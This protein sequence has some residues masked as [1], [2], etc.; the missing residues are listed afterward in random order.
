MK[1]TI[2]VLN[3]LPYFQNAHHSVTICYVWEQTDLFYGSV[4][5]WRNLET[6]HSS[7]TFPPSL[8]SARLRFNYFPVVPFRRP[9]R[10]EARLGR[11]AC[12][13]GNSLCPSG[14]KPLPRVVALWNQIK[15][16]LC[17]VPSLL[18]SQF[19]EKAI[20]P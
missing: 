10:Y 5:E 19:P 9:H 14:K 12:Q 6:S 3:F 13:L 18:Y 2:Y 16:F 20:V 7:Q 15:T 8:L 4:P 1:L 11:R 17:K